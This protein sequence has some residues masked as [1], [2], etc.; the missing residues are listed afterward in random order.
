M[1]LLWQTQYEHIFHNGHL[2]THIFHE[3]T[4]VFWPRVRA[5]PL[6]FSTVYLQAKVSVNPVQTQTCLQ[7]MLAQ[8]SCCSSLTYRTHLTAKPN[9]LISRMCSPTMH[10]S[11]SSN[12][13][14]S[15]ISVDARLA[16]FSSGTSRSTDSCCTR[17]RPRR[18][19]WSA[20][21]WNREWEEDENR[22]VELEKLAHWMS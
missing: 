20:W 2:G 4:R 3:E 8:V 6:H 1:A 7:A 18:T 21:R 9:P 15:S 11:R 13:S 10:D 5:G 12:L 16:T 14:P 22:G 17:G 19:R